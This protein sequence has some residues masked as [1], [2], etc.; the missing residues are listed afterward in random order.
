MSAED[1]TVTPWSVEGTIDYDKLIQKFGTEKISPEL[2]ARIEKITGE[3][4]PM[5]KLSY[6]LAIEILTKFCQNMKKETSSIY[7]QVEDHQDLFIWDIC[8]RGYL[9]NICKK[10][11]MLI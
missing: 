11:L 4:H 3:V 10:N 1:F 5:L 9:L 7:T 2:Q 6:F 8:F